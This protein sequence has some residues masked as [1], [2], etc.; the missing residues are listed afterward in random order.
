MSKCSE[1]LL[2][3]SSGIFN[4]LFVSSFISFISCSLNSFFV[5]FN[6]FFKLFSSSLNSTI[7]IYFFEGVK[8]KGISGIFEKLIVCF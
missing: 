5:S 7:I 8:E 6:M 4:F 3:S 2:I 1:I